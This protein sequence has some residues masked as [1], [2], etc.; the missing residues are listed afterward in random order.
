MSKA[1]QISPL[2]G[3]VYDAALD[4]SLWPAVLDK[5]RAFVGGQAAVL[6]WKDAVT[7]CGCADYQ[8]GGLDPQYVQ[9]YFQ[10]Y[11][12]MDPFSTGQFF[13][14]IGQPVTQASRGTIQGHS[15]GNL[16]C[17]IR[18]ASNHSIRKPR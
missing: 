2:I 15:I 5:V 9:L 8:D 11:I 10:K 13:A 1:E 3:D 14:E 6:C 17:H 7:K 16:R 12:K 18:P 4:A